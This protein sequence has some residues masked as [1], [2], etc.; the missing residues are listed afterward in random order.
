MLK[1]LREKISDFN[2]ESVL[3]NNNNDN[4]VEVDKIISTSETKEDKEPV[5]KEY[6][7]NQ[8]DLDKFKSTISYMEYVKNNSKNKKVLIHEKVSTFFNSENDLSD[9]LNELSFKKKWNRLDMYSKKS[10]I[11]E[12]LNRMVEQGEINPLEQEYIQK[13]LEKMIVEKKLTKNSEIEYD[14][15]TGLIKDI[16]ILKTLL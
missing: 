8:F 13:K 12:Y 10:R 11:K 5:I 1:E 15:N 4:N 6:R 2:N 9:K 3:C 16:P 14:E 7:G